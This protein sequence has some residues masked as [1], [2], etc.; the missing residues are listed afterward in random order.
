MD[1]IIALGHQ[2]AFAGLIALFFFE[3]IVL[4]VRGKDN[5]ARR[6]MAYVLLLWALIYLATLVGMHLK[7]NTEV[8][9]L[10]REKV[11]IIGTIYTVFMLFFP[12]Q[13]LMPG[14]LNWKRLLLILMPLGVVSGLYYVGLSVLDQQPESLWTYE[15]LGRSFWHFN[16]WYRFVIIGC[17]MAYMALIL[18]WLYKQEKRYI[19]WKD[20][21]YADQDYVDISWMRAYDVLM[22]VI[23][24]LFLASL[25]IGGRVI[26]IC[27]TMVVIGSF[28]YLFYKALFH[29]SPYPT[30]YFAEKKEVTKKEPEV[31]FMVDDP[32]RKEEEEAKKD[33]VFEGKIPLYV[34]EVRHWM[35]EEKPYLYTDFKLTDVSRVVQLNR[36][37]LSRLF[38]D[39]FGR[40]FSEVVRSYRIRYSKELMVNESSMALSKVAAMSGFSSEVAFMRA[41]KQIE[42]LSPKQYRD[43]MMTK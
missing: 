26:I 36:S 19:K 34:E 40:S 33:K 16:V 2:F 4:L 41:F 11:S 6:T 43:G 10:F 5:V 18:M 8:Y 27:H 39:G 15:Q 35:D 1:T 25:A 20:D 17:S 38:N 32:A 29:E 14:W 9:V 7:D 22:L 30:D 13:V 28:S 42:G 3:A 23:F 24:L 12:M 37:Y 31:L 21:N